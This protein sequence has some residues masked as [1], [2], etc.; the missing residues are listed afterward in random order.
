M[1]VLPS[2]KNQNFSLH[3]LPSFPNFLK[4]DRQ[5]HISPITWPKMSPRSS[6]SSNSRSRYSR[7]GSYD[8]TSS[9]S[10]NTSSNTGNTIHSRRTMSR[11]NSESHTPPPPPLHGFR[12]FFHTRV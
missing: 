9:S 4:F 1:L 3:F 10:S 11:T 2:S 5:D 6:C 12:D 8:S 7:E